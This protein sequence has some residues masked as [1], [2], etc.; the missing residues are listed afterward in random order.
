MLQLAIDCASDEPGV[1]LA[2]GGVA[3]VTLTW[4][5][6]R[7]H[8]VELLPNIERLLSEAGRT[9]ADVE[10]IFVDL[11]PGGYAALRV[12][13]SIA[14]ALAH[15]LGV[16][17]AGIGR[18]ELDAYGVA[19][20]A[21]GRRIIAVHGAGRG[22]TAWAAYRGDGGAGREESPPC[23]GKSEA[24]YDALRPGD[25]V[26]GDIDNAL[27]EAI[28][29]AGASLASAHQHRVVALAALGHR[30]LAEGRADDPGALVPLY[31][32]APAIGP[33]G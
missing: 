16:A 12:G 9:K 21:G 20:E 14:K 24:L 27:A 8:S 2:A 30:R 33:Q 29:R 18:L 28:Q 5:T 31:L 19:P 6:Q 4:R 10:A 11:G 3:G 17:C 32:R 25:A 22:E 15:A 23:I 26:T 7:N 1:A 13:V